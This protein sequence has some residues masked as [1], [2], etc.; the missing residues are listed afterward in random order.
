MSCCC[1]GF[2]FRRRPLRAASAVRGAVTGRRPE[3]HV[4]TAAASLFRASASRPSPDSVA[5]HQTTSATGVPARPAS[6]IGG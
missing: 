1:E 3:A 4:A 5:P 2:R 6:W